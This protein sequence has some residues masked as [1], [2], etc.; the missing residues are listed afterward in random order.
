M[1]TPETTYVGRPCYKG[2]AGLRYTK[3]RN[4]VECAIQ[5]SKKWVEDHPD[6]DGYLKEKYKR[7][8]AQ[9]SLADAEQRRTQFNDAAQRRRDKLTP[10][11]RAKRNEDVRQWR[12]RNP[13]YHPKKRKEYWDAHPEEYRAHYIATTQRRRARVR[14][15]PG[16]FYPSDIR[17]LLK[18]QK[19][20]CVGCEVDI[21]NEYVV[22][23]IVPLVGGGTNWPRNLQLMCRSCNATKGIRSME[24]FM[25]ELRGIVWRRID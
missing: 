8:K 13:E 5:R 11:Q 15:A 25:F 7:Y 17:W 4:C 1:D 12:K 21:R 19:G 23:H 16:R 10:E 6:F 2:H 14:E 18:H 3:S 22:D 9:E 24:E 20:L